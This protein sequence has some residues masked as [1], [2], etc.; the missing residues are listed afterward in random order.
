MTCLPSGKL[1]HESISCENSESC[2]IRKG[3]RGCYPRQCMVE[4][5]GSFSIFSGE[6][7]SITSV[8]AFELV[9]ACNGAL[10]AEW[11][12]VVVELGPFGDQNGVV[13]VYVYFEDVFITFTNKQTTWVCILNRIPLFTCVVIIF[14]TQLK[15]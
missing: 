5:D 2:Q 6:K 14:I 8:G 11:F 1:K 9:K 13:A 4:A 12:R 10:E 3:V 15:I 7:W